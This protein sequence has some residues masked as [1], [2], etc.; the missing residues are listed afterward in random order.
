MILN[1]NS[2]LY[3]DS[4]KIEKKIHLFIFIMLQKYLLS[5]ILQ[6][7]FNQYVEH[8]KDINILS[9]AINFNFDIFPYITIEI[10]CHSIL[11]YNRFIY[12]DEKMYRSEEWYYIGEINNEYKDIMI[13]ILLDIEYDY[14]Y[15][16]RKNY[17]NIRGENTDGRLVL[18]Y[19][20]WY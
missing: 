18:D 2:N 15:I 1:T 9:K 7:V 19:I 17:I 5:D 3:L 12:I 20:S 8:S 13:S 16:F 6:Y 4:I 14:E 10:K 11:L